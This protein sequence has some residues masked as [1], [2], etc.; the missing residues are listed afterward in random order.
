MTVLS[1]R[2]LEF[3]FGAEPVLR[4]VSLELAAGEVVGLVGPNGSGKTTLLR[5]LA[6]LLDAG[7]AIQYGEAPLEALSQRQRAHLRAY[8]PQSVAVAFPYR[9]AEVVGMGL[10]ARTRFYGAPHSSER[11]DAALAEVDF[12]PS[13]DQRFDWL[14][15]GE[16]QQALVARALVQEAGIV[17]LDEPTSA[18]DLRHRAA[19]I[20]ELR[21]RAASGAGVLITL[22]DLNLA[23][24][25]CDRLLLLAG[26][27]IVANGTPA[28]VL[29]RETVERVY[30]VPVTCGTHPDGAPTVQLDP[31]AWTT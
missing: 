7:G 15:G 26:G 2:E 28:E 10:A 18:L 29:T 27:E 8:V 3:S 21:R 25:A 11:I 9:V 31:R 6:G 16:R 13:R 20:G 23:A 22:H 5:C 4:R 1:A 19:I 24:L 17:L 12:E 30:G 14:S